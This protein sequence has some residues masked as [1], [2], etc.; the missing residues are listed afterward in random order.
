[1]SMK[2]SN[3]T[4]GNRTRDL[5]TCSAVPQPSE[6]PR[7]LSLRDG[8]DEFLSFQALTLCYIATKWL[9]SLK[10]QLYT[11]SKLT[12]IKIYWIN[13]RVTPT[14]YSSVRRQI[15][16]RTVMITRQLVWCLVQGPQIKWLPLAA[17]PNYVILP[18]SHFRTF[19]S[20]CLSP[21]NF[22]FC[23]EQIAETFQSVENWVSIAI[24]GNDFSLLTSLSDQLW[25]PP[26]F[27][28]SGYWD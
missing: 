1:M 24:R 9:I 15:K 5:P 22:G 2:N 28:P 18:W 19:R 10:C 8:C 21:R 20:K 4:I 13:S 3:D 7:A 17:S 27:V 26:S 23:A 16:I 14:L 6:L 25:R 11:K 12:R